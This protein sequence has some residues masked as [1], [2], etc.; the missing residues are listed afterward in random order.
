MLNDITENVLFKLRQEGIETKELDFDTIANKSGIVLS[1]PSANITISRA[2]YQQLTPNQD[3]CIVVFTIFLVVHH[4]STEKIRRNIMMDLIEGVNQALLNEKLGL[5]LQD[6]I[7]PVGF[8]DVTP[9][10]FAEQKCLIYELNFTCSYNVEKIPED[11]RDIGVLEAI[12]NKYFSHMPD[13]DGVEDKEG[14]LNLIDADGGNA[15]SIYYDD[16]DLI[17]GIAGTEDFYQGEL[18]GGT[19]GSTYNA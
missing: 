16:M 7:K 9:E 3:R 14:N 18:Y 19:S 13:D 17:G 10:D 12:N 5:S 11:D 6:R 4:M 2:T 1:K 15:F 8:N